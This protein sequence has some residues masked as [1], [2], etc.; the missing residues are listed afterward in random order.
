MAAHRVKLSAPDDR[1]H[2]AQKLGA[3]TPGHVC[4]TVTK[5]F[6]KSQEP[7][8]EHVPTSI[9]EVDAFFSAHNYAA[10]K[11]LT[12]LD[13]MSGSGTIPAVCQLYGITCQANDLVGVA[14]TDHHVDV[15]NGVKYAEL[16]HDVC[17]CRCATL[18]PVSQFTRKNSSKKHTLTTIVVS[19]SAV[20]HLRYHSANTGICSK[21][22]ERL[23][24]A[25][26]LVQQRTRRKE[27]VVQVL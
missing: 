21:R 16:T 15:M 9:V 24:V 26:R 1:P 27:G 13:A 10:M 11:G 5:L 6:N 20:Q 19:Q 2:F 4:G 22:T 23:P 18:K 7:P 14:S 3:Y 25:R 12:W 17:I 8:E